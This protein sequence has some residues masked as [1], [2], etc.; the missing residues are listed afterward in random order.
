MGKSAVDNINSMEDALKNPTISKYIAENDMADNM[1][2]KFVNKGDARVGLAEKKKVS[3]YMN[4]G[5]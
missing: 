4:A 1:A 2:D 3:N 5:R